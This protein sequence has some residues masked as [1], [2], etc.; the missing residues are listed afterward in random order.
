MYIK[1]AEKMAPGDIPRAAGGSDPACRQAGHAPSR[2]LRASCAA[3]LGFCGGAIKRR[4]GDV[5]CAIFHKF[6]VAIILI[7]M[8]ALLL[9]LSAEAKTKDE[10]K[11]APSSTLMSEELGSAF[12]LIG[13]ASSGTINDI[14]KGVEHLNKK[15]AHLN[16][17]ERN[18]LFGY[19]N[20]RMGQYAF[21]DELFKKSNGLPVQDYLLFYRGRIALGGGEYEKAGAFFTNLIETY[22]GSVLVPEARMAL[23]EAQIHLRNFEEARKNIYFYIKSASSSFEAFDANLLLLKSYIEEKSEQDLLNNFERAVMSVGSELEVKK[24]ETLAA[25]ADKKLGTRLNSWLKTPS[26]QYG[27]ARS[28]MENSQ[29]D[30]ALSHVRQAMSWGGGETTPDDFET[31]WLKARIYF[32][33]HE[34]REA[35][36]LIENLLNTEDGRKM[37]LTLL[38][39]LGSA[40]ARIDDYSRSIE[41]RK[42]IIKEY[43]GNSSA[44]LDSQAKIA[45]LL[46]DDAKYDEAIKAWHD[47]LNM[48]G[49]KGLR[50]KALWYIAWS[51]YKIGKYDQAIAALDTV[52]KQGGKIKKNRIDDRVMYWKARSLENLGK[53]NA[54]RNLYSEIIKKHPRGYYGELARRR[55]EGDRRGA[56]NFADVSSQKAFRSRWS[57]DV[58]PPDSLDNFWHLRRAA[59][60]DRLNLHEEAAGE[61][62]AASSEIND[63]KVNSAADTGLLLLLASRNFAHDVSYVIANQRYKA[64]LDS[65]PYSNGFERFIWEQSYPEAYRPVV[66]SLCGDFLDPRLVYAIMRAESAF[67][68]KVVSSAGAVGLMQLMPATAQ[69]MAKL[70]KDTSFDTRELYRP[71][72]NL[73]YGI[74]YLKMLDEMF[75]GNKVAVIASYNAGEEAVGRWLKHG[76]STDIEEFIEEIPYDETN[77][78]VK[79]VLANYWI[80]QRMY[81]R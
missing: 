24:L 81:P 37:R 29:W 6:Y 71:P 23:A 11:E 65:I 41:L 28:L 19:A 35:I 73:E 38:E 54:A 46:V 12:M 3:R 55:L 68:P 15:A 30:A 50:A 57:P 18:F 80:L 40:Y 78:Y 49:G 63:K 69:K 75:A 48:K 20:Y 10:L 2:R 79:K 56:N 16:E 45:F 67:R 36:P 14:L 5:P 21:A 13:T 53:S 60:F 52:L 9:S 7:I 42:K 51:F 34:Y 62:A 59:F 8:S 27:I 47:I 72:K 33:A 77:L 74:R 76:Y 43:A 1:H 31:K 22:P 39:H 25:E 4:S 32:K 17:Q 26:A 58:P 70:G 61:L 64:L 66:E 44:V